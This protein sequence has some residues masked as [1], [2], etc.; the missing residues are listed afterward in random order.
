MDKFF[1]VLDFLVNLG[2]PFLVYQL[3]AGHMSETAALVL[4][5]APP[6]LW[7]VGQLIWSRKLDALSLLVIA[8]IELSLV[9]TLL[10]G[11]PRLLLVRESFITGIFGLVFLGSLLCPKPLVFYLAKSTVANPGMSEEEFTSGWSIPGFRSTF[12]LMTTVW[13]VGLLVEATLKIILAFTVP[14]GQFLLVSPIISYGIYFGL[15]GW[16]IWYGN[17]RRKLGQRLAAAGK[18]IVE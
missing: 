17:Q 9:A 18:T 11:S 13:G 12:Y 6:I 1:V 8:G 10:G 14:I 2:G 7:S 4:S 5:S 15:L 3:A 16:S